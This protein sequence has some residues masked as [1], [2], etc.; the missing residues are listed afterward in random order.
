[1]KKFLG[2]V[3]L[4]LL[5]SGNVFASD[6]KIKR[7]ECK[8]PNNKNSFHSKFII[9]S[10]DGNKAKLFEALSPYRYL[11]RDYEIRSGIH[12]I[13]F[14]LKDNNVSPEFRIIRSSGELKKGWTGQKLFGICNQMP[15]DFDPVAYFDEQTKKNIAE[16]KKSDKF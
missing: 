5:L 16:K 9:I 3:V 6:I 12:F 13:N 11:R 1:M 15:K 7:I 10:K 2:I 14:W 4:G 8:N